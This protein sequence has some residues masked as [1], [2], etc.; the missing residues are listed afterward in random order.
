MGTEAALLNYIDNIQN[1]LNDHKYT[2]FIFMDLSKAF[3]VINHKILECKLDHYG[4][5]GHF[6]IFLIEFC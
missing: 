6:L 5:R 4:F 1:Q 2:I 3:D